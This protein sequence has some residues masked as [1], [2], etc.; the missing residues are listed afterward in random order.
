MQWVN[1]QQINRFVNPTQLYIFCEKSRVKRP[2]PSETESFGRLAS[3]QGDI[4]SVTKFE[5]LK[6]AIDQNSRFSLCLAKV[7]QS[8]MQF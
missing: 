4:R 5:I 1:F 3:F 2:A 7:Q 8:L 6:L